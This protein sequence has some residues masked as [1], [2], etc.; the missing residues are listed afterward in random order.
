MVANWRLGCGAL[1]FMM[2]GTQPAQALDWE[3]IQEVHGDASPQV[4]VQKVAPIKHSSNDMLFETDMYTLR[5]DQEVNTEKGKEAENT[6]KAEESQLETILKATNQKQ[7]TDN[8]RPD[9][10]EG[11]VSNT[12]HEIESA[13]SKNT[14]T[15]V[16]KGVDVI[17]RKQHSFGANEISQQHQFN[18]FKASPNV[19][20]NESMEIREWELVTEGES[21]GSTYITTTKDSDQ[22]I[23]WEI[24]PPGDEISVNEI[25]DDMVEKKSNLLHSELK[26]N[27]EISRKT[28]PNWLTRFFN[29]IRSQPEK[30]VLKRKEPVAEINDAANITADLRTKVIELNSLLIAHL[31]SIPVEADEYRGGQ[32]VVDQ[33]KYERSKTS[34]LAVEISDPYV[35]DN[36]VTSP[37]ELIGKVETSLVLENYD[38]MEETWNKKEVGRAVP[39]IQL[40]F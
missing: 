29:G 15:M 9:R 36:P 6:T 31:T 21:D 24:V 3:L 37:R 40:R 32:M 11:N 2:M 23:A 5:R 26:I 27:Q 25:I 14:S 8:F 33:H 20:R 28:K 39:L 16:Y 7:L 1:A 38:F 30:K 19:Y 17:P 18:E 34:E 4:P 35:Y 10:E 13:N 12:H 22:S